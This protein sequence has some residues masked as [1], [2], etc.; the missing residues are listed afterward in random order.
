MRDRNN[1]ASR[2]GTSGRFRPSR[3]I[4][5]ATAFALGTAWTTCNSGAHAAQPTT[6]TVW[7]YFSQPSAVKTLH[8][9]AH[10]FNKSHP[11]VHVKFVF[12]P[13]DHLPAKVIAAAGAKSGPD[14]VVYNG[15]SVA[16]LAEAG[17]LANLTPYWEQFKGRKEF[18][19]TVVH[20]YHHK[21]YGVQGYINLL[22]LWYNKDILN[23]YHLSPPKT[24]G[25]L[26]SDLQ[27]IHNK[28]PKAT[29]IVLSGKPNDQG[30]WQAFPWLSAYGWS[31]KHP[32]VQSCAAALKVIQKW[33]DGGSLP[34]E[35]SNWGQLQPFNRFL[36]GNVAFAENGNWEI[37]SAASSAK[38]K[39]GLAPMP[40]SRHAPG[41]YLGGE[42]ES[43]GAFA[44][45]RKL[46]WD[47]LKSTYYSKKGELIYLRKDNGIPAR[48]D[49]R[50]AA[51][52]SPIT[53]VF[54]AEAKRFGH[55]YPP[56]L[57]APSETLSAELAVA[58][59]WSS[60]IAGQSSAK[61]GCRKAV[62]HV[63]KILHHQSGLLQ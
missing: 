42:T 19:K 46:A 52:Y 62:A 27:T 34:A 9:L 10:L 2:R 8:V 1:L 14:V 56:E 26:S 54:A 58:Q 36:V 7:E 12:V 37:A 41:I 17:A 3:R 23:K 30:E 15:T 16:S 40:T 51:H 24:I 61:A 28:D 53:K 29:G 43:I 35:A 63:K 48:K 6:L 38:F 47:F 60:V 13:Y 25:Q 18:P 21:I 4:V 31:Y 50:K 11:H 49:A 59:E 5:V 33:A 44:K 55:V 20:K 22:G 39:Y 45:N 57:G 32:S